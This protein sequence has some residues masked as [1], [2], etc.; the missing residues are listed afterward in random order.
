[1]SNAARS[2][3]RSGIWQ[4]L[5]KEGGVFAVGSAHES[6]QLVFVYITHSGGGRPM[7][8]GGVEMVV[9]GENIVAITSLNSIQQNRL[10]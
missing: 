10:L 9:G 1:M 7:A 4:P 2:Q 5:T 3:D 6:V 8:R